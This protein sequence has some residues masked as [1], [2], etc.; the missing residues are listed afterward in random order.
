MPICLLTVGALGEPKNAELKSLRFE[1]LIWRA[2]GNVRGR[3]KAPPKAEKRFICQAFSELWFHQALCEAVKT[4]N[5]VN[6]QTREHSRS[7]RRETHKQVL[8]VFRT[9]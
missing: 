7:H 1:I 6:L 9:V 5:A 4:P 2:C 8:A 3:W